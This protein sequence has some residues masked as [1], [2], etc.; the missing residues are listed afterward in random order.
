MVALTVAVTCVTVLVGCRAADPDPG[1]SPGATEAGAAPTHP[2]DTTTPSG[3][4]AGRSGPT[5]AG[6]TT[7]PAAAGATGPA[8]AVLDRP[9]TPPTDATRLVRST[10]ATTLA[11][12]GLATGSHGPADGLVL[13]PRT[14]VVL[15]SAP[16]GRA[17]AVLPDHQ[18]GSP[19]W[20]P[21]VATLGGWSRVLLPSR[22]NGS[23]AWVYSDTDGFDLARTD[24]VVRVDLTAQRMSIER[25]GRRLGSW[26][27]VVGAAGTPTPRGTTFV[28]ASVYD[29]TN[30]YSSHLLPL[31]SHSATLDSFGGGPGTVAV[32]GWRDPGIFRRGSR[33]LSHGCIRVPAAALA[34]ARELPLG[35]PVVV[36]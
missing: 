6:A 2:V 23:S 7:G 35:T 26:P 22:P 17:V 34:L 9:P 21:V 12:D 24:A 11:A 5:P 31:G 30:A 27:V 32:H 33:A 28:M 20:V 18:L 10:T 1:R 16:G 14:D 19:T 36:V 25:A 13:H 29:P 8:A 4:A 15:W 3:S